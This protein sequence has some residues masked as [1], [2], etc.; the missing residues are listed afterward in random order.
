MR[1]RATRFL[2][3]VCEL[4]WRD[5]SLRLKSGY[6]RNDATLHRLNL[7]FF[8]QRIAE[9]EPEKAAVK[10]NGLFFQEKEKRLSDADTARS[11]IPCSLFPG[12]SWHQ[13]S[14]IY[15]LGSVAVASQGSSLSH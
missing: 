15:D 7:Y 12:E 10:N 11:R 9:D 5:P 4:A 3:G 6:A 1:H 2:I 8:T 13:T 14:G